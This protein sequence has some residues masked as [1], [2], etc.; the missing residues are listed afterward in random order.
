MKTM[1]ILNKNILNVVLF[2]LFVLLIS[3]CNADREDF[4]GEK[5]NSIN[6]GELTVYC[7]ESMHNLL[8]SAITMYQNAYPKIVLNKKIVSSREAMKVLLSGEAE[9]II[10][11]RSF[12]PDE[13]SLMKEF[14]VERPEMIAASDALVFFTRN[15]TPLDTINDIQIIQILKNEKKLK[16]IFP[17]FSVEPE[18][19]CNSTNSS[20]FANLKLLVLKN[21]T[22]NKYLNVFN[23]TDSV[24]TY[25]ENNPNTIGVAYLSQVFGNKNIKCLEIGF[26]NKNGQ[27][28]FPQT[29]HQGYILQEKYPYI[30]KIG[31]YLKED[32]QNRAFWFASFISKELIVQKY[33]LE[34]GIVP[35]YA[36][37]KIK[38]EK[39]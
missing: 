24:I 26:I 36:K 29:V 23:T 2:L 14:K 38:I 33:L 20:E 15:D 21:Q 5:Y 8:D 35:E 7:E 9:A 28:I 11:A 32:R 27:R 1:M 39:K 6:S 13:D 16:D 25:V 34:K 30:N 37:F 12:L 18:F 31:I 19:V 4:Q 22:L 10:S 17:Q 3:S